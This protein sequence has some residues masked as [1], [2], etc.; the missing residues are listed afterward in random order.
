[1]IRP[2]RAFTLIEL[3]V[4]IAIVALLVSIL[5]PALAGAR[6][7]GRAAVCQSN[8]KQLGIAHQCYSSDS[9]RLIAALDGRNDKVYSSGEGGGHL[10]CAQQAYKILKKY[11]DITTSDQFMEFFSGQGHAP[12][13]GTFIFEQYSHVALLAY[14]GEKSLSPVFACPEDRAR[15]MWQQEA[16]GMTASTHQPQKAGNRNNLTWLPYSSSYQLVPSAVYRLWNGPNVVGFHY[17]AQYQTHD[18]YQLQDKY[19]NIFGGRK[20]D[21]ILFPSQK[22]AIA[23]SQDRHTNKRELFFA[24]PEAQQ[25]LLFWDGS[26][27]TRKTADANPGW[28]P[29]W[30][31]ED[32]FSTRM[33]YDPDPGFESPRLDRKDSDKLLGYYRWTRGGLKGLDYGGSEISTK[34]WKP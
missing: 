1:M 34:N 23:D 22:V 9:K 11:E 26:V 20:M 8:L 21:E 13:V 28:N 18:T 31:N 33:K 3:L 27:S 24:Y 15:L 25:P 2:T 14:A 29:V 4:V 19:M 10:A 16:G 17:Y 32:T 5:L 12:A 30:P 7:A 6:R